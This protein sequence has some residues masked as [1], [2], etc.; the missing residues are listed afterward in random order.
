[1]I[2]SYVSKLLK[3]VLSGRGKKNENG[4]TGNQLNSQ[5]SQNLTR[6]TEREKAEQKLLQWELS[7][8]HI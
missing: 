1:M 2:G 4:A 6:R 5:E 3:W 8:I 7:L